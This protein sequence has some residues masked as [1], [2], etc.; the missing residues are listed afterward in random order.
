[1]RAPLGRNIGEP[2]L[3]ME[4]VKSS[5]WS[6]RF[7]WS[8]GSLGGVV[9]EEC[10]EHCRLCCRARRETDGGLHICRVRGAHLVALERSITSQTWALL[11]SLPG[12]YSVSIAGFFWNKDDQELS[13]LNLQT[14][15]STKQLYTKIGLASI[16][17]PPTPV[18]MTS[19][20]RGSQ[21]R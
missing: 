20:C 12:F 1:M 17:T 14:D 13:E 21:L 8:G 15:S 11:L 5:C 2:G 6:P 19:S 4:V 18:E 7:R 3:Y 16:F 9:D 10:D